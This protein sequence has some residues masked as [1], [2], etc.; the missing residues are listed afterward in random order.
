MEIISNRT[1]INIILAI[2]FSSCI[3]LTFRLFVSFR[4]NNIQAIT[5]NY[6]TASILSFLFYNHHLSVTDVIDT[7]WFVWAIVNGCLFILVFY[8]FAHSAQKAGVAITAVASKMSVIIPVSL[9]IFIYGDS[10]NWMK[11]LG[12]IIAFP[13]F[14]LIFSGRQT[15]KSDL[16]Y[17]L[18]PLILFFGTGSNDSVM[19][20]AQQYYSGNENLLFLGTVFAFSFLIGLVLM[21]KELY[22]NQTLISAR[23][24]LV[25]IIL[26]VFNFLSTLYFLKS[27]FIFENT[28]FFPVFNVSVV[29]MGALMGFLIFKEKLLAQNMIGILLAICTITLI[30]LG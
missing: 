10:L 22:R 16:R 17:M 13:A 20:H 14:Y 2:F 9:G 18:L 24:L 3:I 19:K 21:H 1:M 5:S 4:I 15:N 28:V 27:L 25:G 12:I 6:L 26:G 11:I 7:P 23:S 8:V 30:A 29:S